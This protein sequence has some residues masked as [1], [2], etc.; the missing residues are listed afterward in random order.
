M[1]LGD[2]QQLPQVSQGTHPEPVD[3]SALGWLMD[4]EPTL[5]PELGYFLERTW[6]MHPTLTRRVSRLAY[7]DKLVSE[8]SVT[9]A[10]RLDGLEP[11]L[12]VVRVD[13]AGNSV[14]S[15]E[16]AREVVEQVRAAAGVDVVR[17]R[18]GARGAGARA[19]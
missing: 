16:E 12:H 9:T 10:R 4:G 19:A 2:P 13:H 5:P 15:I 3:H 7:D 6:R 18:G 17:P 14:E 8:E 1:L 11:G